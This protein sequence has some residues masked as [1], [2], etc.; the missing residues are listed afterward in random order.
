MIV[1]KF[2]ERRVIRNNSSEFAK[3]RRALFNSSTSILDYLTSI[4]GIEPFKFNFS[5]L[6]N[7]SEVVEFV[8]EHP[9]NVKA[10]YGNSSKYVCYSVN[11]IE[12]SFVL[13]GEYEGYIIGKRINGGWIVLN[14]KYSWMN[15]MKEVV[16]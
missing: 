3:L 12:V 9:S 11:I 2:G 6:R 10:C 1:W 14:D 5:E 4:H 13:N 8:F 16:G 15:E 7:E